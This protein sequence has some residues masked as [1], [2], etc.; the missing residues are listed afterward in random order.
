MRRR[1]RLALAYTDHERELGAL[2]PV[3]HDWPQGARATIT[4]DGRLKLDGIDR[5]TRGAA[6][7]QVPED[8]PTRPAPVAEDRWAEYNRK[9]NELLMGRSD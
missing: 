2:E 4:A 9:F 6:D 1:H 8:E 5:N 3:L 7:G